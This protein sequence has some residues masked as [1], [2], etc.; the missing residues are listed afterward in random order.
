MDRSAQTH[1]RR[2]RRFHRDRGRPLPSADRPGAVGPPVRSQRQGRFD[3]PHGG[4]AG[5]AFAPAMRLQ[6]CGSTVDIASMVTV[7]GQLGYVHYVDSEGAVLA[8]TKGLV[9]EVG[10]GGCAS[11]SSRRA[12]SARRRPKS[13]VRMAAILSESARSATRAKARR[14]G[15]HRAVPAGEPRGLCLR[16]ED[17][18]RRRPHHVLRTGRNGS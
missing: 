15:H 14:P 2:H 17:R 8:M 6:G 18:R 3:V 12:W 16:P 13:P 5:D 1:S 11:T 7:A 10:K 9:I 4:D